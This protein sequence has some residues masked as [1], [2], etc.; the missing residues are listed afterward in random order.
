MPDEIPF[1]DRMLTPDECAAWLKIKRRELDEKRRK[2]QIPAI[3]LGHR[4]IRYHPRT[5]VASMA[6]ERGVSPKV[7][8]AMFADLRNP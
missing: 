3:Q 1:L 7:I 4:T 2:K 6:L 5:V 8:A